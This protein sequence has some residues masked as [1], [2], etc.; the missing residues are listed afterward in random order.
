M[1]SRRFFPGKIFTRFSQGPDNLS[2]AGKAAGGLS[3]TAFIPAFSGIL[4]DFLPG[5]CYSKIIKHGFGGRKK[6]SYRDDEK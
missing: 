4:I 5:L 1:L 6:K 2:A 3:D